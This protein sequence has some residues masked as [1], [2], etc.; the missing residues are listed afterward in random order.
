MVR[1]P[2][3]A[4]ADCEMAVPRDSA[5]GMANLENIAQLLY[6]MAVYPVTQWKGYEFDV[7]A[8]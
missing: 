4:A 1:R 2:G 5:I 3:N 7:Q 6:S 8:R